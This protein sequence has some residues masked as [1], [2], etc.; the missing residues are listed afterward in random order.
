ME[1]CTEDMDVNSQ[2]LINNILNLLPKIDSTQID[3]NNI[4]VQHK[5]NVCWV[6][7]IEGFYR[8]IAY[9]P[10]TNKLLSYTNIIPTFS[11]PLLFIFGLIHLYTS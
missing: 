1:Y 8:S 7:T 10:T 5:D 11:L 4:K 3:L 9:D 2:S 6:S